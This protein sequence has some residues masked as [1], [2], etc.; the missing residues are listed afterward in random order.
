MMS[1]C[2]PPPAQN[3]TITKSLAQM[4]KAFLFCKNKTNSVFHTPYHQEGG[5]RLSRHYNLYYLFWEDRERNPM[6]GQR[7]KEIQENIEKFYKKIKPPPNAKPPTIR[8][9]ENT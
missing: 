5:R 9:Q 3:K 1:P 4:S 2:A 7:K 8:T 6:D